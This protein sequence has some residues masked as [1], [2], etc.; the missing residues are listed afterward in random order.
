MIGCDSIFLPHSGAIPALAIAAA[1]GL[2]F[3]VFAL[4]PKRAKSQNPDRDDSLEILKRRLARGDIS[5]EEFTTL[6]SVL[7]HTEQGSCR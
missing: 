4:R 3:V 2:L 7:L 6:K 1:A 5:L